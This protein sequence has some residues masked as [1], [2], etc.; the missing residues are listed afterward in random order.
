MSPSGS[1]HRSIW[2]YGWVAMVPI[3]S[4]LWI[5]VGPVAMF[6]SLY[7]Y[8][9][10]YIVDPDLD[11]ISITYPE[12][13]ILK[14]FWIFGAVFVGWSTAYA[15]IMRAFGGH[16]S[17][18]S[19]WPVLSTAIRL[20]WFSPFI[21]GPLL[22]IQRVVAGGVNAITSIELLFGLFCGLCVADSLHYFADKWM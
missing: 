7:G 12:S 13:K 5:A 22:L 19:H 20:M 9:A 1:T 16:R 11:L 4:L 14:V 10:G 3:A 2:R 21:I 17:D 8:A 18:F 15:V 6:G